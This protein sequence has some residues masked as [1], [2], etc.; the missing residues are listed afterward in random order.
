M[1]KF[2]YEIVP[3]FWSTAIL[4][5]P[6]KL[7]AK[8]PAFLNVNGH[9]TDLGKAVEYKQKRCIVQARSGALALNIEWL[10]CGELNVRGNRHS[11]G[12]QL[13]FVG[14]HELG[15]FYLAMRKGLD[16]LAAH[17]YADL[18]RIGMTGL[19]GGGWQTITLS[20]LDERI[21]ATVPVAGFSSF[22]QRIEANHFGDIGDIEQSAADF[23][24]KIDFPHLVGMVAPRPILLAYNAED[25]C[26]FRAPM[27]KPLVYDSL[28]PLFRLYGPAGILEWHENRDPGT[29]NYQLD[30][31]MAAYRFFSRQFGL[32][33]VASEGP[34]ASEVKSYEELAVGLS[35]DNLTILDLARRLA[36]AR[37]PRPASAPGAARKELASLIRRPE[38]KID[39]VWTTAITKNLEVESW[40]H[41][42]AMDDGLSATGVWLKAIAAPED[43]PVTIVIDDRGKAAAAAEVSTLVNRGARVLALDPAFFGAPWLEG[44]AWAYQ[45]MISAQGGRPLGIE[46]A[47]LIRIGRWAQSRS[48]GATL[49]IET[50]GPRSQVV[51][52]AAA[53]LDPGLFSEL[54]SRGGMKALDYVLTKPVEFSQ[55]PDLFCLDLYAKTSLGDLAALAAPARVSNL[56]PLD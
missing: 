10:G 5:E 9:A 6:E 23:F 29:H 42:F 40:A 54:V 3:G 15:L 53:A 34:A 18:S 1:R 52:L 55:A 45:Q 49:R 47:Q 43:G 2:R 33:E 46:V 24:E 20:A 32:P 17:P 36:S 13:D 31:R 25:D 51:A 8:V 16:F 39:H 7:V 27:V 41:I 56:D 21:R 50:R 38:S 37:P 30:N 14:T 26:C 4:Y 44:G 48:G 28:R 11:Y 12:A 35:K 19:S 22:A